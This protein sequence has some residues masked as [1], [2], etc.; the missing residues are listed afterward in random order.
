MPC[1]AA[2]DSSGDPASV[3]VVD[4]AT[5]AVLARTDDLPG[6]KSAAGVLPALLRTLAA[7]GLGLGDVGRWTIGLGPGSFAGIRTGAALVKGLCLGT[8]APYRGLP[9]SLALVAAAGPAPAG[10]VVAALFDGRQGEVIVSLYEAAAD[11]AWTARGAAAA[12]PLAALGGVA[13]AWLVLRASDPLAPALTAD[14]A[15][16]ARLR[17]VA[18]PDAAYLA[19]APGWPWPV[20]VA[21]MEASVAPVYVRPPVFVPPIAVRSFQMPAPCGAAPAT[22]QP[23]GVA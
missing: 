3:A 15:L 22:P 7:A 1:S 12:L 14:P 4:D 9:S 2:L 10:T 21:A 8:G 5:G 23:G 16:A 11:D 18:R 17:L 6:G 20:G 13:A 19:R